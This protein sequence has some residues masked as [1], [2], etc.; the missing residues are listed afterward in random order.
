MYILGYLVPPLLLR[1]YLLADK[2]LSKCGL[3]RLFKRR[4]RS[5]WRGLNLSDEY[6]EV[7]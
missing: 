6:F 3:S 1:S 5:T 4:V 7:Q 2:H